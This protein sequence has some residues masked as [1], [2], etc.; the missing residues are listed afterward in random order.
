MYAN[1]WRIDGK[2]WYLGRYV[3]CSYQK[4]LLKA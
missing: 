2:A 4:P 3:S 1:W